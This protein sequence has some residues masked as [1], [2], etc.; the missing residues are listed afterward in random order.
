MSHEASDE[1][2]PCAEPDSVLVQAHEV[3]ILK[4]WYAL[5][6]PRPAPGIYRNADADG[7]ARDVV[8]LNIMVSF[9]DPRGFSSPWVPYDAPYD[10]GEDL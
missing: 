5:V 6:D 9:V 4:Y 3:A 2:K 1:S 7:V 10:Q 8:E